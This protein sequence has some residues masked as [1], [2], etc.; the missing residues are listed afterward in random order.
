MLFLNGVEIWRNN[1][2]GDKTPISVTSY[3][4]IGRRDPLCFS[5]VVISVTNLVPGTNA[6]AAAVVQA[7]NVTEFDSAFA[8]EIVAQVFRAPPLPEESTPALAITQLDANSVRLS[9]IGHGYALENAA[10]LTDN[11]ASYPL[12]PWQEVPN[13]ANPFTNNLSEPARFFRLKN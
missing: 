8:L 5:N 2:V 12:G 11:S 1:A 9:W 7:L 6:L 10:N 13:M 4:T 3:A